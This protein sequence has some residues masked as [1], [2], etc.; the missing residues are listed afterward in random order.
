[1]KRQEKFR[2]RVERGRLA[3]SL[4]APSPAGGARRLVS[5]H[6]RAPFLGAAPARKRSGFRTA[7]EPIRGLEGPSLA[8]DYRGH[9]DPALPEDRVDFGA[10]GRGTPCAS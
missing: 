6:G 8:A 5:L 2:P 1:M 9:P 3:E 7:Y 10:R 4:W